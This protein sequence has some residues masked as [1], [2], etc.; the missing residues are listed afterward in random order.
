MIPN[1]PPHI[2]YYIKSEY[3]GWK[4]LQIESGNEIVTDGRT[5]N[6]NVWTEG[7]P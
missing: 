6:A 5:L 2:N 7:K 4:V 1:Y 3:V